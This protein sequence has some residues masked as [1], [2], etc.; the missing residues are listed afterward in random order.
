[1]ILFNLL[2]KNGGRLSER[3]QRHAILNSARD[4]A[5]GM[6]SLLGESG[7]DL[8]AT[9]YDQVWLHS[10]CQAVGFA[11][12]RSNIGCQAAPMYSYLGCQAAPATHTAMARHNFSALQMT[13]IHMAAREGHLMVLARLASLQFLDVNMVDTW[14][15]TPLDHSRSAVAVRSAAAL[16]G[17]CA[18]AFAVAV[19]SAAALLGRCAPAFAVA[20]R[21]AAALLGRCAPAFAVAAAAHL[22]IC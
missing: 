14:G 5:M 11:R 10:A 15:Y 19:R 6:I 9:N 1:V 2:A 12:M 16:L 21:S 17:R 22:R 4:G 3:F 13:G 20:V 7:A 18:P 8:N